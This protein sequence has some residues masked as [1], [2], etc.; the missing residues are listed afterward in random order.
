MEGQGASNNIE[1]HSRWS[2]N[3][4]TC[5][6]TCFILLWGS[7]VEILIS[8]VCSMFEGKAGDLILSK[9]KRFSWQ[10]VVVLPGKVK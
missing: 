7:E 5:G 3:N 6:T 8:D 4:Q 2:S 1:Q 9:M 10:Q